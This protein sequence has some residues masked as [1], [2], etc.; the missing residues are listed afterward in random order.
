MLLLS[1]S[2]EL[3]LVPPEVTLAFCWRQRA[4]VYRR[5]LRPVS[6]A[7]PDALSGDQAVFGY[8]TRWMV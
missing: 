3:P 2:D 8:S 1:S 6:Y 7:I 5:A 4:K